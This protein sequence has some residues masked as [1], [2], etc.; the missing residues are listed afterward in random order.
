MAL[1]GEDEATVVAFAHVIFDQDPKWGAL[2]DNLHVAHQHHRRGIGTA[3]IAWIAAAV[4]AR[5][6]R[7]GL[8]L[9]VQ[10]QNVD[11]QA[12]YENCGA[13]RVGR[14]PIPPPGGIPGRLNGSPRM[15]R[16]AWTEGGRLPA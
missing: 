8:Y 14:A 3:L 5:P 16:Y 7:T 9:W 11:A 6:G 10:E 4:A 1:V 13:R 15:L 12:F 2:L